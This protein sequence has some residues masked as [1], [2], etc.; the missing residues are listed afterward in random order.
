MTNVRV[1]VDEMISGSS[2]FYHIPSKTVVDLK[3]SSADVLKKMATDGPPDGYKVQAQAYGKGYVAA[4]IPVEKVALIF[5]PRSG[6]LRQMYV[7]ED[8][9]Q[10]EVA[11]AALHRMYTLGARLLAEGVMEHPHRW[12]NIEATPSRLCGWCPFLSIR[13]ADRGAD[14]TGCP[15]R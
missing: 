4:G 13:D 2:D 9:F 8:T 10:P 3:T 7:W 11:D 15:G 14:H 5:V 12:N 6:W 1:H